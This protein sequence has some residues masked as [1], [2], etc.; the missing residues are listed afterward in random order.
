MSAFRI[1]PLAAVRAELALVALALPSRLPDARLGA[2]TLHLHQRIAVARLAHA[3]AT[4]G[5]ALLADDVGLGKTFV[6]LALARV[7]RRAVVAA[8]AALRDSWARASTRAAVACPF[9]SVESLSRPVLAPR[10][11]DALGAAA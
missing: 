11:A 8:P 3:L 7:T 6:A 1:G 2:V 5:G 10:G 9:V 4:R